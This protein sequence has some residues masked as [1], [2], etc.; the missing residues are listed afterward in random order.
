[1]N[2]SNTELKVKIRIEAVN[3]KPNFLVPKSTF[4]FTVRPKQNMVL[5][6]LVKYD[7]TKPW[8]EM[9]ISYDYEVS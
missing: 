9:N 2:Q 7:P 3:P 4:E 8:G 6:C 1:M 5:M